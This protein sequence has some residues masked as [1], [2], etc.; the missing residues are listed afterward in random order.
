MAG[1]SLKNV[2][3]RLF[4]EGK[5]RFQGLGEMAFTD[6]GLSG[7]LILTVSSLAVDSLRAGK[8]L[9]LAIDLKPALDE[10]QLD[11]RLERDCQQRAEEQLASVLRGLLPKEM[12]PVCLDATAID[13]K[14]AAGQLSDRRAQAAPFLAEGFSPGDYRLS[15]LRRGARH[16]RWGRS[17]GDRPADHGIPQDQGPVHRRRT[18]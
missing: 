11:A 5:C 18:P 1:L 6:F 10:A 14:K 13:P 3:V 9:T 15:L 12:V 17:A 2:G 4:I 8:K 7:P 16:R